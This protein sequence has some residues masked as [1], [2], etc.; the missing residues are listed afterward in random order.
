MVGRK[1]QVKEEDIILEEFDE[2]EEIPHSPLVLLYG[3]ITDE[4]VASVSNV[5]ISSHY[6]KNRPEKITLLLNTEGGLLH[7]AFALVEVMVASKIP[8]E[9]VAIGQCI[10]AGVLIFMS[11]SK[12]MRYV[13]PSCTVMS[14]SFSTEIQGNS[15]DLN[16]VQKELKHTHERMI[17]HYMEHTEQTKNVIETHLVG[18][19]DRWLTPDD[20]IKFGI[21]DEIKMIELPD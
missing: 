9:T 7:S 4:A 20:V 16:A 8:I 6:L 19:Q 17:N 15:Y 14:H 10:S 2:F 5:I 3:E 18:T 12:G 13:T 21:A 11:G 1:K